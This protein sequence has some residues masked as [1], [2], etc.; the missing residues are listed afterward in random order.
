[1]W[2]MASYTV[3][4]KFRFQFVYRAFVSCVKYSR[5]YTTNLPPFIS[6]LQ[7]KYWIIKLIFSGLMKEYPKCWMGNH[8]TFCLL[9]FVFRLILSLLNNIF[10]KKF[11]YPFISTNVNK[12]LNGK[13]YLFLHKG[14]I[15]F[16]VKKVSTPFLVF[17]LKMDL[18]SFWDPN[19]V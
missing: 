14:K 4:T 8:W 1:M 18:S 12:Q 15:L 9:R 17:L 11:K 7:G 2:K 5:P 19:G 3:L 13:F 10:F 6:L 16:D